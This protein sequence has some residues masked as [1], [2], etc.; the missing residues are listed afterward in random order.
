MKIRKLF[1]DNLKTKEQRI[2]WT[3]EGIYWIKLV[4]LFFFIVALITLLDQLLMTNGWQI[5]LFLI[6][7]NLYIIVFLVTILTQRKTFHYMIL[8]NLLSIGA[9]LYGFIVWGKICLDER[10]R[11]TFLYEV[12][13]TYLQNNC[14]LLS[15]LLIGI[16]I[17][18]YIL[19]KDQTIEEKLK[20]CKMIVK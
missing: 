5:T 2:F 6:T 1:K 14:L 7:A 19:Y 15:I 4:T 10:I 20:D 3:R 18:T 16:M 11:L 13:T 12:D 9:H 17:G 8:Y